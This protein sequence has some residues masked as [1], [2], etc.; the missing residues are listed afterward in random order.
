[1]GFRAR[2]AGRGC[3]SWEDLFKDQDGC[4]LRKLSLYECPFSN[5]PVFF[6]VLD[7]VITAALN[8]YLMD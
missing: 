1:M 5:L 7:A 8:H 2:S 6:N 4:F 3:R